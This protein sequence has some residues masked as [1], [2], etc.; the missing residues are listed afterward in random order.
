MP[1]LGTHLQAI[2]IRKKTLLTMSGTICFAFLQLLFHKACAFSFLP[3]GQRQSRIRESTTPLCSTKRM[4][5]RLY[6]NLDDD[7]TIVPKHVA[8]ICD[9]NSRWA[10]KRQLPTSAGHIAGADRFVDLLDYLKADGIQ[11]CTF[12]GFSTENW[13]RSAQEIEGLFKIMEQTARQLANRVLRESSSLEIKLLGDLED[14]RIPSGLKDILEELQEKTNGR[15]SKSSSVTDASTPLTI[16]L[17]INYGGR[18]DI[19]HA[20]QK[21]VEAVKNGLSPAQITEETLASYLCTSSIPD[22]DMIIRTSGESRLSNF[23]LWN[24]A[25]S[26]L[27]MTPVL[28]PDFDKNC[29]R[30]ALSWYQQRQ[31]RFGYRH[32]AERERMLT[33]HNQTINQ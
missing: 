32:E 19:L 12:Y 24:C 21:L 30:N 23:M 31:R 11:Y 1:G 15:N 18:Q 28:W 2:R 14:E 4:M 25:Y 33:K 10:S 6:S 22:P 3:P 8:F 17:A 20:T 5:S 13:N 26:E 29:W 7:A 9:G 16:C 27:Y